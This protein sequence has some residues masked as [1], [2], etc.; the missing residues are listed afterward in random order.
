MFCDGP[1]SKLTINYATWTETNIE[2]TCTACDATKNEY[3][4]VLDTYPDMP[5]PYAAY[6]ECRKCYG[7]A[8][9]TEKDGWKCT[10][11]ETSKYFMKA[12][13]SCETCAG[14]ATVE[15]ENDA[16]ITTDN[17]YK[18]TSCNDATPGTYYNTEGSACVA[19][20]AN[21]TVA[22]DGLSCVD[23]VGT[24]SVDFKTCTP[25]GANEYFDSTSNSCKDCVGTVSDD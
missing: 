2:T 1:N 22:T 18:C 19:C 23:C 17:E 10:A 6:T 24:V 8:S 15:V 5:S 9:Y 21:K 13:Q 3:V 11:C 7:T 12:T 20:G 14:T 25:C 4:T 16:T